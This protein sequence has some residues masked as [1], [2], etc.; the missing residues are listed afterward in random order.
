MKQKFTSTIAGASIFISLLGLFSRG[1]GFI[2][3]MI[4]ASN[5]GL[6]TEFDLYLVGAVLPVTI[7][8]IILYIG[9]NYF[10]PGFQK[11]DSSDPQKAKS[12]YN[13][14]FFLFVVAA[15]LIALVLLL[16]NDSVI[17][18]YMQSAT[19]ESREIA[20]QIFKLFLLTIPF[21]AGISIF[22][23]LLQT[24]YEF[25]YPAISVLFLNVSII[26]LLLLFS[27][28][29]GVFI[30][31]VGYI[32]GMVLQFCY[33]FVKSQKFVKLD[34]FA[35]QKEY[36]FSKSILSSS[37]VTIILIESISQ[38]YSLFDRYFYGEISSGGIA[39]LNYAL[40]VWFLPVSIL[41]ISLATAVFP[42]ITKAIND[43]S[44]EQIEKIYNESISMN[45]FIFIP[46]A[47]ILFFYGDIL[48]KI[49]FERGKFVE[50]STAM[51]F[52]VLR[53]Y[54]ISLVFYSVYSVFNKIFYS[55][56]EVK[57]LLWITIIGLLI[58]LIFNLMLVD[59]EQNGLALSTSIS[60]IFFF[61]ASYII[62][63]IKLKI[64]NQSLF[65]KDFTFHFV[66]CLFSFLL[67]NVF[68][69]LFPIK[70][71]IKDGTII[72]FFVCLYLINSILLKHNS[73]L[74]SDRVIKNLNLSNRSKIV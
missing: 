37:L 23:A 28:R 41:S 33:L 17:N 54:S 2:R 70:S 69:N 12:Y 8:T 6:E 36:S 60:F 48:I 16:L 42:M 15:T 13:Q 11:I 35:Y 72:L 32:L 7:N 65:I 73:I 27:D 64:K 59:L 51:T 40:I 67:I 24:V 56:K 74:I 39:S 50:E 29:F 19:P 62:L 20:T 26:L 53:F 58:K 45:T 31:P 5:F 52:S 61:L 55:I 34:L 25:K 14:S 68:A 10:I 46:L 21:A 66:N 30:I 4:F 71:I 43:F 57:L 49:F 9:Q 22:S 3:E 18:F 63:N 1:L 38:L 44:N 47:F